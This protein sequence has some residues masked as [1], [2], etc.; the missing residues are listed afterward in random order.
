MS[1]VITA[2]IEGRNARAVFDA[3]L[4]V[5]RAPGREGPRPPV[6]LAGFRHIFS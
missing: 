5:Y 6:A 1:W 3:S 2:A 4:G